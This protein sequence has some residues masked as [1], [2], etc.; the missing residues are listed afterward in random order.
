MGWTHYDGSFEP[1]S[2]TKIPRS[3]Q[4]LIGLWHGFFLSLAPKAPLPGP[5]GV[6]PPQRIK[7]DDGLIWDGRIVF[8][9]WVGIG[10]TD[11]NACN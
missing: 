9:R 4:G 5:L 3:L 1:G 2:L 11:P 10:F 7:Q 8:N 6:L